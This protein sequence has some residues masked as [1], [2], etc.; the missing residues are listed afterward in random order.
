MI[1]YCQHEIRDTDR[2]AV[3]KVLASSRLTQGPAVAGF[4][5]AEPSFWVTLRAKWTSETPT[6]NWVS[7][8]GVFA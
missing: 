6:V 2:E 5:R 8:F 3:F 7:M 1:P 4:E